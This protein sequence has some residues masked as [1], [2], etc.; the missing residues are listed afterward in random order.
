MLIVKATEELLNQFLKR[1]DLISNHFRY[2]HSRPTSIIKNHLLTL[3]GLENDEPIAYGHIDAETH[4]WLGIC[5]LDGYHGK[6]YGTQIMNELI[7]YADINRINLR[8]SVDSD[9]INAIHLYK[10][11]NFINYKTTNSVYYMEREFQSKE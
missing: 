11:Y 6:G 1:S 5:V 7:K 3:I 10:K 4:N 9:N 8:L 2:F